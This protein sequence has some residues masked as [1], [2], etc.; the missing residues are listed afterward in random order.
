ME[1]S[2]SYYS[3]TYLCYKFDF[4]HNHRHSHA[5]RNHTLFIPEINSNSGMHTFPWGGAVK[6]KPVHMRDQKCVKRGVFSI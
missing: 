1:C 6:H 2:I 3:P 5:T 4:V